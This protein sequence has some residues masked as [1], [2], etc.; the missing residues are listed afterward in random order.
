VPSLVASATQINPERKRAGNWSRIAASASPL[1]CS[2]G[3][4][5]L[6]L[7]RRVTEG[8]PFARGPCHIRPSLHSTTKRLRAYCSRARVQLPQECKR[9]KSEQIAIELGV[10]VKCTE[11][12]TSNRYTSLRSWG[13]CVSD[14]EPIALFKVTEIRGPQ[15]RQTTDESVPPPRGKLRPRGSCVC[16][17]CTRPS[18]GLRTI[19]SDTSQHDS[20]V[21]IRLSTC[22]I[23]F[24]SSGPQPEVRIPQ[25]CAKIYL[26]LC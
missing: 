11:K 12:R 2:H 9:H 23:V 16:R 1:S 18:F 13:Q 26:R 7:V 4:F 17:N 8:R 24:Y 10:T 3:H 22:L 15:H 19:N 5:L 21:C 20:D 25:A 6:L 14:I